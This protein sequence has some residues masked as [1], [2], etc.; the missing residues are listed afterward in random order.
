[1]LDRADCADFGCHNSIRLETKHFLNTLALTFISFSGRFVFAMQKHYLFFFASD[2]LVVFRLDRTS[3]V[4]HCLHKLHWLPISYRIL[5]KYN[6]FTFKAIKFSKPTYLSSLIK[7]SSLT[8]ENQ[9]S[10]SSV[11]L[12][13]AIG[14][15]GF[16]TASPIEWNVLS[17]LVQSHHTITGFQSQLKTYLFRVAYPPP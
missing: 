8:H 12:R 5:S 4:T 3:L 13:K 16:A 7:T 6:L 2:P 14:R 15:Q 1:M 11:C 10:L 9:L 17:L